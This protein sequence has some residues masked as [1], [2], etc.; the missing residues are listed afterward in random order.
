MLEFLINLLD[1]LDIPDVLTV[2]WAE[3]GPNSLSTLLVF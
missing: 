1:F 2:V 3:L